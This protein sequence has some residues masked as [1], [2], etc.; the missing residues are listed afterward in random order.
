MFLHDPQ[1]APNAWKLTQEAA[2][3]LGITLQQGSVEGTE[4]LLPEFPMIAKEHPD[5]LSVYP[6]VIVSS[7][8]RPQQLAEFA[9]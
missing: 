9:I 2:P 7:H 6:D 1:A 8:P 3:S 4:E 5:A